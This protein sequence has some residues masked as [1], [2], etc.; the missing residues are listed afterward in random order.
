MKHLILSLVTLHFSLFTLHAASVEILPG[1]FADVRGN[2]VVETIPFDSAIDK[3]LRWVFADP[4]T[5]RPAR[6]VKDIDLSA[7]A[8]YPDAPST[9]FIAYID[10]DA[11][12]S[13]TPGEPF[14]YSTEQSNNPNNRTINLTAMSAI[15]PRIKLWGTDGLTN[16]SD[17]SVLVGT[18][19]TTKIPV[20][21]EIRGQDSSGLPLILRVATNAYD[22]LNRLAAAS[23]E[24][25]NVKVVRYTVD[26]FTVSRA[27][28]PATVIMEKTFE[29]TSRD[30]LHEGDF[31]SDGELD[32]DWSTLFNEVVTA[33]GVISAGC[34]V[35]NVTYLVA[36]N[37]GPTAFRT[38]SDTNTVVSAFSTL[39]TRR[40]EKTR[41][42]PT[43]V[44]AYT[45]PTN[46]VFSWKIENEDR[47]SSFFGTTYTAFK[48]VASNE[49]TEVFN[50]G[51]RRL[52]ARDQNGVYTFS[53]SQPLELLEPLTWRVAVYNSKFKT[54]T[55]MA[56]ATE[57]DPFSPPETIGD[58]PP[59]E[60]NP[61]GTV[62]IAIYPGP[63]AS[64]RGPIIIEQERNPFRYRTPQKWTIPDCRLRRPPVITHRV[65]CSD[66]NA[67][68]IAYIDADG[69]GSYTP[70]E[71]FGYSIEQ[72]NN[73][74]NRTI[75]LTDMSAITPRIK[76]WGTDGLANASDRSVLVGT[77]WTTNL[78]I[79]DAI[80]SGIVW[81]DAYDSLNHLSA[82]PSEKVNVKVV[83]YTVDDYRA[84]QS[85]SIKPTVVMDKTLEQVSRDFLHEGDFLADGE[86]DID[87]ITLY[88]EI[89]SKSSVVRMGC[90]VT[91]VSY[92]ISFNFARSAFANASDT[93]QVPAF[94][95][96][97]T[98]RFEKTRTVPTPVSAY[99]TPT[100]TVFS[101]RIDNEDK[102]ASFFGTTYTAF[103][104]VASNGSTEV[105]NSG[106][107]RLPA[108]DQNGVYTFSTSQPL[109]PLEPLTWR[110]AVYN[111]KFK[112]DTLM[113]MD[114]EGDPFSPAQPITTP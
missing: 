111:A 94:S 58:E 107:L 4:G 101:F 23:G 65:T 112:T 19:W 12:G 74:N 95:T 72:S 82:A 78:W 34:E 80:G 86:L 32:L 42:I 67:P 6:I 10:A 53:T 84:Y 83:R 93:T 8:L 56:M 1:P 87:W 21:M 76:L 55:I 104:I 28:A 61:T 40:F 106:I 36:F 3:P 45:T 29:H 96:L 114:T 88:D 20:T 69:S 99:T 66:T 49:T 90:E 91:N 35:T 60:L 31:L 16:A 103:K 41:K 2:L 97:V 102:W 13:Y 54:D 17:R 30:F 51:I 81:K 46:T 52:P 7:L 105:W 26:N 89:V 18:D 11:S 22:R 47:W 68:F 39:V 27:G 73:P 15:T 63:N 33:S 62:D 108:R 64:R 44:S 70:G 5:M 48:I 24:K 79:Q 9:N 25:V 37:W 109:E 59:P 113:A 85:S 38:D 77:D 75:N 14:G 92:L 50:S 100:N 57:G 43:P 110:V 98:R 71:P